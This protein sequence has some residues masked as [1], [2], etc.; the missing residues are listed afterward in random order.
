MTFVGIVLS[1]IMLKHDKEIAF[2]LIITF[3]LFLLT[4]VYYW[5]NL[6]EDKK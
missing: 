2:A 1:V 4:Q 3:S 5:E 6:L